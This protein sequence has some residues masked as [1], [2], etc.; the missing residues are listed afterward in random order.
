MMNNGKNG[1]NS[2]DDDLIFE[3]LPEHVI[4]TMEVRDRW[5]TRS[6]PVSNDAEAFVVE[7]L[8]RWQPGQTVRVAFLGGDPQLHRDIAEA[9]REITEACNIKLDFG[10]NQQTGTFRT[11][12][13]N[14]QDDQA[15]IRVSFD[16]AGY[17]SPAGTD[18]ISSNI[19]APG[20]SVGGSPQHSAP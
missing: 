11:W 20:E 15:E 13:T 18:S 17:F 8:L 19:G 1:N 7:D 10:F 16:E 14:D 4:S 5:F 2:S 6:A 3:A 12:S 9:T